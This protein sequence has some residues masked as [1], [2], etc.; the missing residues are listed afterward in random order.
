MEIILFLFLSLF[1][2]NGETLPLHTI[3][4]VAGN[5][6]CSYSAIDQK[7]YLSL[8]QGRSNQIEPYPCKSKNFLLLGQDSFCLSFAFINCDHCRNI[9]EHCKDIIPANAIIHATHHSLILR[10]H[11]VLNVSY[12]RHSHLRRVVTTEHIA[13][14]VRL[15]LHLNLDPGINVSGQRS[16][17]ERATAISPDAKVK[18]RCMVWIWVGVRVRENGRLGQRQK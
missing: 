13:H 6:A 14:K 1:S 8:P 17:S 10:W 18:V 5:C 15:D 12:Q 2:T 9:V 7:P 11:L 16:G 4:R 3:N